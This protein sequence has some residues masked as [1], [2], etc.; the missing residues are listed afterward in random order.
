MLPLVAEILSDTNLRR[1][2]YQQILQPLTTLTEAYLQQRVNLGR[3]R[4]INPAIVTRAL[5]GALT[6]NAVL[7]LSGIDSQ[8]QDVSAE[9]M[10]DESVAIVLEGISAF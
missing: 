8:Y 7:K 3:F 2:F 6:L 5:M 10:I 1:E 9:V 4:S